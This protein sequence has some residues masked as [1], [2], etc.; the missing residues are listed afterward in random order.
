MPDKKALTRNTLG[1]SATSTSFAGAELS[2]AELDGFW[3]AG[4]ELEEVSISVSGPQQPLAI[5]EKLGPSPFE[6]GGFPLIGFLATT[7]EKVS[8]FALSAH[9]PEHH[10]GPAP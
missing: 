7:Y 3:N 5:L 2:P 6:R 4:P 10:A 8:R 1:D 9:H